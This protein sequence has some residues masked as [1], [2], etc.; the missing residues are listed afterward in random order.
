[1]VDGSEAE[2][3]DPRAAHALGFGMVYQHFTLVPSLTAAKSGD[4]AAQTCR[5]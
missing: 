2:V 3:T 5:R 4:L 1:M